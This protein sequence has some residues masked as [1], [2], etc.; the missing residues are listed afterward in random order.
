ME[1]RA[2]GK[3]AAA[4]DLG[5]ASYESG[6]GNGRVSSEWRGRCR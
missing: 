3:G 2:R 6:F 1:G 5:F 4:R